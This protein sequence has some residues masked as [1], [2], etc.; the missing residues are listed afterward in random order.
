MK[1]IVSI[2][3]FILLGGNALGINRKEEMKNIILEL[4][5]ISPKGFY[6]IPQ[7]GTSLYFD[8][9]GNP[10]M[11]LINAIDGVTQE[12]LNYGYP[13]YGDRNPSEERDYLLGNLTKLRALDKAVLTVN[14]TDSM[15]GNWRSNRVAKKY[16][17]LNYSALSRD[18]TEIND[19]L[20]NKN[21]KDINSLLDAKNFL[22]L[23]NPEDFDTKEEYI[24][25][26]SE[27]EQDIFII[28]PY[29]HKRILTKEDLEILKK[30]PQGGKR[31][32]IAYL[33]IGEAGN[34]RTYWKKEWDEE[35]P[36]WIL[37]ENENWP[38]DYI[39]KYWTIEWQKILNQ[40]ME[41]YI[42]SNF[43]GVFL[44]TIDTYLSE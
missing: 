15:Y 7:N 4:R 5:E 35:K 38:G 41:N 26:L 33:S 29:F 21:K 2:I 9:E 18:V 3:L 28:D 1:I 36:S 40:E 19:N 13:E 39:T 31:I 14:Y 37:R 30:K 34:Y 6:I 17:F 24:R 27:A 11:E 22:Y 25:R 16:A 42:S 10:D 20:K 44:D 43:D 32:I 12:S 8:Q 23:L